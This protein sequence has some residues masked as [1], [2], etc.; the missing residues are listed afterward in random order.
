MV[1]TPGNILSTTA[2][3]VTNNVVLSGLTPGLIYSIEASGGPWHAPS[4]NHFG[5]QVDFR[6][7]PSGMVTNDTVVLQQEYLGSP[8]VAQ[9]ILPQPD[10]ANRFYVLVGQTGQ[11]AVQVADGTGPFGDNTGALNVVLRDNTATIAEFAPGSLTT[12]PQLAAF[13]QNCCN[14]ISTILSQTAGGTFQSP[15]IGVTITALDPHNPLFGGTVYNLDPPLLGHAV[16][17]T[18]EAVVTPAYVGGR[19]GIIQETSRR[20]IQ[21]VVFHSLAFGVTFADQVADSHLETGTVWFDSAEPTAVSV[22]VQPGF[23]LNVSWL[24]LP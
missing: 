1:Y 16:G 3:V 17:L 14:M 22:Y 7:V 9:A 5:L 13:L 10:P 23:E 8:G 18:W 2:I 11:I 12:I 6:S 21:V 4:G 20:V 19:V 15:F 24:V